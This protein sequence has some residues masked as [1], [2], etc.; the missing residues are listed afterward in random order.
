MCETK[1]KYIGTYKNELG[2]DVVGAATCIHRNWKLVVEL[3]T[4]EFFAAPKNIIFTTAVI[5][6][7]FLI[8]FSLSVLGILQG[9]VVAPLTKLVEVTKKIAVGNKKARVETKR[10]DE[11]G[12]VMSNFN[13]MLDVLD[14]SEKELEGAVIN[15]KKFQLAAE[16]AFD[17]IVITDA[18]AKILYLNKATEDVTGYSLEEVRGKTPSIWGGQMSKKY[19]DKM[20]ETIKDKK[21]SFHGEVRN[22]RKNGELWLSEIHIAPILSK[23]NKILFYVSVQRDVTK[24]KEIDRQKSEFISIV[25]HQLKTPLTGMRLMMEM[26]LNGEYGSLNKK[27]KQEMQG[28]DDLRSRMSVLVQQLLNVSRIESGDVSISPTEQ[29]VA[30][31]VRKVIEEVTPAAREKEQ[32]I[33]YNGPKK[34]VAAIDSIAMHE[35]IGNLLSN[36]SKYSQKGD[37]IIVS[38]K[39]EGTQ[40]IISVEDHGMGI[41]KLEQANIFGKFFRATNAAKVDTTGM[42]IGLYAVASIVRSVGGKVWFTSEKDEGSIF[43]VAL[44]KKGMKARKGKKPLSL[45]AL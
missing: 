5:A 23:R 35:V 40:F 37:E 16:H 18:K 20:W 32:T 44:P 6:L 24:A 19:Y 10:E 34:Y 28:L 41:P 42:G 29:D 36:A 11:I 39:E 15:L 2:K 8:I 12:V 26:F 27:Q 3:S 22:K 30:L 17:A 9:T 38:L 45:Q 31:F 14:K 25:S 33:A 1:E 21:Q 13:S 7:M 4:E 43:Y